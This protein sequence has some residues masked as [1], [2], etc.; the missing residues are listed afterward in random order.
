MNTIAAPA[1]NMIA[2]HE[3]TDPARAAYARTVR[4]HPARHPF[5]YTS[6]TADESITTCG[7]CEWT[8]ITPATLSTVED[9]MR[10]NA[11][12]RHAR[13]GHGHR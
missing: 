8:L 9:R 5:T 7:A 6:H 1:V 13:L 12:N 2:A 4:P 11:V 10:S 3:S